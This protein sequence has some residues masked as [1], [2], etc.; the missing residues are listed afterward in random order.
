MAMEIEGGR[1]RPARRP[2]PSVGTHGVRIRVQAAGVNRAD[3]LQRSG[4][5]PP[6]P[7][8]SDLP[9]L[10]VAGI[11]EK[12]GRRVCALLA[13]GGYAQYA[14]VAPEL[15]F[16][17]P[18]SMPSEEAA[19]L[20]EGL[21]TVWKNVF[22]AGAFE[23]GHTVLVHGGASGIGT[24]AI[25]M[26]RVFGGQAIAT[27]G[28]EEKTK[29]CLTLGAACAINYKTEDFVARTHAFTAGR[30][31]DIVLDMVGGDY[32]ARNLALLV[33]GGRHVSI[34]WPRG[35]HAT[36][37][38]HIVMKKSLVLTGSTLRDRPLSDK[39]A[40]AQTIRAK[41]WPHVMAG[42]IKPCLF[43]SFPLEEANS[44]LDLLETGS[45]IGKLVLNVS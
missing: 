19:A 2:L 3:L 16:D 30:G 29:A 45:V 31:V 40:L 14:E 28:S 24:L 22:Q 44:A 39:I 43:R 27:A 20:P 36:I 34:A 6:P 12:T 26:V 21:F 11:N 15:C 38:I 13:G 42:H 17:L 9:G 5:Y 32:V 7:G 1:L 33:H 18:D 8:A 23:P 37:P 4:K 41:V 25:Q 35:P 10:E